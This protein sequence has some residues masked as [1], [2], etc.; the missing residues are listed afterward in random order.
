MNDDRK[1]GINWTQTKER[2]KKIGY[3]EKQLK[4]IYTA[5]VIFRHY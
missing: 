4:E 2:L 1:L 5:M 3:D